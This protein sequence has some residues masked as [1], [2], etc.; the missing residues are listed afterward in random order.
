MKL[1]KKISIVVFLLWVVV[2]IATCVGSQHIITGSYLQLER[3]QADNNSLRVF[4][5]LNQM[6]EGVATMTTDWSVWDESYRFMQDKNKKFTETN[7]VPSSFT[8]AHIDMMLFYD[9]TGKLIQSAVLDKQS[10][11]IKEAPKALLEYVQ[12]NNQ[13]IILPNVDSAA[14]GMIALPSGILLAAS[15]AIV[16]G[17]NTGPVRGALLMGRILTDDAIAKIREITKVNASIFQ[18]N[19]IQKDSVLQTVY[20]QLL[21]NNNAVLDTTDPKTMIMYRLLLNTENYP[22]AIVKTSMP[23]IIYQAG[24]STI[25]YYNGIFIVYSIVFSILLWYAL[26]L[27]IIKRIERFSTQ[28]H[29]SPENEAMLLA[30]M[31]QT[32]DELSHASVLYYQAMHDSL[33]GLANR[34]LLYEMFNYAVSHSHSADNKIAVLFFDIDFFKRVNDAFGHAV[35][36]NLLISMAKRLQGILRKGDVAAR[37]GGDEFV[38]LLVNVKKDKLKSA[39]AR[40]YNTLLDPVIIQGHELPLSSSLGVSTYPDDD[41]SIDG[42]IKKADIALY[43][44]KETGRHR[45]EFYSKELSNMLRAVHQKEVDLQRAIENDELLLHYQPIIDVSTGNIVSLEALLRWHHSDG[46][47]I[48][49]SDIIPIAERTGLI[50]GIGE[51]ALRTVCA[52]LVEWQQKGIPIVPIAVNLSPIQT[53]RISI[54]ALIDNIL[55]EIGLSPHYLQLELT[56]T[57]FIE[58]NEDILMELRLLKQMGIQLAVDDFGTGYSGLRY[59]KSLP[60]NKIKID[61]SFTKDILVNADDRA[62]TLAIIDVAHQLS[63]KVIAEGVETQEQFIFLQENKVDQVQGY[64]FS[65]PLSSI[66]CEK[67]LQESKTIAIS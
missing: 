38:V 33:T 2:V 24:L 15:H 44:A 10:N 40:V 11:S 30:V 51:W 59:L 27:L 29:F 7:L 43:Y 35:G 21:A 66:E 18:I 13:L 1:R 46:K 62:I 50:T 25:N 39:V 47:I 4:E 5:A 65:K 17:N 6:L 20:Q 48:S 31:N 41:Q 16:T 34:N 42:L 64:Y 14:R 58:I 55:K 45:C 8:A 52:Q 26:Q 37:L 23:R 3:T 60:V 67:L 61:Q 56:E 12:T 22:I 36:D 57:G 28:F 32:P 54:H 9:T 49:A 19:Q 63:L 53:R